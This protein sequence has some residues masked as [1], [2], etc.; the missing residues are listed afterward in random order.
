MSLRSFSGVAIKIRMDFE[1]L[2]FLITAYDARQWAIISNIT[3]LEVW[4]GDSVVFKES[5]ELN[6]SFCI[7]AENKSSSVFDV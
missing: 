2:C 6:T 1:I 3:C 4:D 5:F 7:L